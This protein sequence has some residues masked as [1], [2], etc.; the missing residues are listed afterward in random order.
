VASAR[1]AEAGQVPGDDL[2]REHSLLLD[3]V[4]VAVVFQC[5]LGVCINEI[6]A[7]VHKDAIFRVVFDRAAEH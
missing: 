4:V 1:E 7:A 5:V 2:A 6:A 3:L